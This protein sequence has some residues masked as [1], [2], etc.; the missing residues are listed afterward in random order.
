VFPL[1]GFWNAVVYVVTS[2]SACKELLHGLAWKARER[3]GGERM[4][5]RESDEEGIWEVGRRGGGS[6]DWS[7]LPA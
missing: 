4:G 6:G 2:R 7:V 1:Q 5:T 3:E